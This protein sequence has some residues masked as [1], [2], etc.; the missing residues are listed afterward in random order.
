MQTELER[1]S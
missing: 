1:F